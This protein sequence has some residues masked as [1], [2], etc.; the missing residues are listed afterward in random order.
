MVYDGRIVLRTWPSQVDRAKKVAHR[1][2]RMPRYEV[3]GIN[4]MTVLRLAL[5]DGVEAFERADKKYF[6][7]EEARKRAAEIDA[8]QDI[9]SINVMHTPGPYSAQL[10]ARGIVDVHEKRLGAAK[11]VLVN[12]RV[13]K[14]LRARLDA[15][16]KE[17]LEA[18]ALP[19]AESG[20][21]ALRL[22][23]EVGLFWIEN[24][25]YWERN[26]DKQD[27]PQGQRFRTRVI[28]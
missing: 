2:R 7:L 11:E 19:V 13:P 3:L 12:I 28:A 6:G 8:G 26:I 1:M 5:A 15:A 9:N 20:S 10:M 23:L 24:K 22:I 14:R 4:R 17:V 27:V 16:V 25:L 21:S 18:G